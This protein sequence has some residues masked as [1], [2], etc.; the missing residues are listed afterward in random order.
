MIRFIRWI[1]GFAL[2]VLVTAFA[3]FN[4]HDIPFAYSPVHDP[5]DVPLF[6][7]GLGFMALGFLIGAFIVWLNQIP[8]FYLRHKQKKKIR[9]LEKELENVQDHVKSGMPPSDLF[10]ALP[11]K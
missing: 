9:S 6:A 4:R 10:P 1:F 5:I 2:A 7:V 11:K 3:V 8:L